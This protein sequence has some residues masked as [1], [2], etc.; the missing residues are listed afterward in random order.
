MTIKEGDILFEKYRINK[1]RLG[2]G[3]YSNVYLATHLDLKVPWALKV[4]RKGYDGVLGNQDFAGYEQRFRLETQLGARLY[5]PI[6]VKYIESFQI[7]LSK[8]RITVH[9][10]LVTTLYYL[11]SFPKRSPYELSK[12]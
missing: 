11:L 10:S 3:A 5:H 7:F 2:P 12:M 8:L 4:L 6:I 9:S 1:C